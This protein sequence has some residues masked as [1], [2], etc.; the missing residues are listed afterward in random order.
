MTHVRR[1]LPAPWLVPRYLVDNVLS[2]VIY[3]CEGRTRSNSLGQ[4]INASNTRTLPTLHVCN[5]LDAKR[6]TAGVGGVLTGRRD[7]RTVP[8]QVPCVCNAAVKENHRTRSRYTVHI[9]I[10]VLHAR[11]VSCNHGA[12]SHTSQFSPRCNEKLLPTLCPPRTRWGI[13]VEPD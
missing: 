12:F 2:A 3:R 13:P 5:T 6:S 1:A 11:T 8:E 10:L 7:E 9:C 4:Q